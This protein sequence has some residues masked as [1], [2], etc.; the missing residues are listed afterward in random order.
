MWPATAFSVARGIIQKK[1]SSLKFVEKRVRQGHR[2][3][4]GAVVPGPPFEIHVPILRLAPRLLHT[5]NT[6]FKKFGLP[7]YFW[8][9]LLVFVPPCC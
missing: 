1:T 4:G 3:R 9:L 8:P 5:S 7:F 2:Q 6:E